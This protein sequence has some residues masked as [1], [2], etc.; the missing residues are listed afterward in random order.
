MQDRPFTFKKTEG[1]ELKEFW[2]KQGGHF[3]FCIA[4]RLRAAKKAQKAKKEE[5][6]EK[7]KRA[8]NSYE[9]AGVYYLDIN[10]VKSKSRAILNLKKDGEKLDGNDA[11]FV[12]ELLSQHE[13]CDQKMKD[14]DH[15]EV[16]S[17]P[18]FDKTRCFFV[19]RKDGSKE[20]FSLT[21]CIM[22]LE[23]AA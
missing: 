17:H 3:Q 1:D 21:K 4:N 20:D 15:F 19:V 10:K 6:L 13:K 16:N 12:K 5:K 22:N 11:E 14:F 18:E 7:V 9:I 2:Q 23:K 8:K